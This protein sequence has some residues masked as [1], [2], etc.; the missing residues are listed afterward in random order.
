MSNKKEIQKYYPDNITK[1]I[2]RVA[3]F[4]SYNQEAK[5]ADYVIYYL[6][7]LKK[8]VDAIVFVTDN[9]TEEQ[10][11]KKIE[12]KIVYASCYNH[13]GYDFGSYKIG[14]RIAM[15]KGLLKEA[16]ELIF[17]ND[18]CY[19]PIFP[20]KNVFDTMASRSCDVWGLVESH[21]A[22]HHIQSFFMVFRRK[23]F[24]SSVFCNFVEE[25]HPLGCFMDYVN[26]YE[27]RFTVILKRA[28]F[29]TDVY[30][31]INKELNMQLAYWSGHGNTTT[32]P[33]TLYKLGM[34]LVKIKAMNGVF[35][36]LLNEST[37]QLLQMIRLDNKPLYDIIINDLAHKG[38]KPE[39]KWL[40]P[41]EIIGEAKIV[42]FDVFD[43]LLCRP[44]AHP[45]DLFGLIEEEK[46]AIGFKRER[47]AAEKAARIAHFNQPDVT[48]DQIYEKID[49]KFKDFMS[50]ELDYE[51]DLLFAKSDGKKIYD[52]AV[53]Q[54]KKVIAISDMYLSTEFITEVLHKNGFTDIVKVYVS[55]SIQACKGNGKLFQYVLNELAIKPSAMV[56]I[57]DNPIADKQAPEQLGIRS[58]LRMTNIDIIK[59]NNGLT[60]LHILAKKKCD[61]ALSMVQ[62]IIAQ[63]KVDNITESPLQGIGYELGG[64][65]AIGYVT[66]IHKIAKERN[67]DGIIFVSRDGYA[68]YK[69]YK[70]LYPDGIKGYYIQGSRKLILRN[71]YQYEDPQNTEY[72]YS[73]Y[74]E[75]CLDG[76]YLSPTDYAKHTDGI[77]NWTKK[78]AS[79]Y[80]EYLS[81]LHIDGNKLMTVDMTTRQYTSLKM[82]HEVLGNRIDCG[83]FSCSYGEKSA[84]TIL[85]YAKNHWQ[86]GDETYLMLAEELIT[87][88]ECSSYKINDDGTFVR[89]NWH[90]IEL[91]RI[92]N[93]KEILKGI[94]KFT[95]D[96]IRLTAKKHSVN[97]SY[98]DWLQ[99]AVNFIKYPNYGTEEL[100]KIIYHEDSL[101]S[102]FTNIH[103]MAYFSN[104]KETSTKIDDSDNYSELILL[105]N[106][107]QKYLKAIRK[108]SIA[109]GIETTTILF[110]LIYLIFLF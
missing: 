61:L 34:P 53:K 33:V 101:N 95:E 7:E 64:P 47:I 81:T 66:Y 6:T 17:L 67:I 93:Y 36:N 55:N 19:G 102:T 52:E 68:L 14:F 11:L 78:N 88:P 94:Y 63:H 75:E 1:N 65:L 109:L 30:V 79:L 20:F 8:E 40:T 91:Q 46:Q 25:L 62:S 45:T 107:R 13:K 9:E 80:Q 97:I 3:V 76:A 44:F 48:L 103:K 92:K 22:L 39:D 59:S 12:N 28:G 106:K 50:I 104:E 58:C 99:M 27:R 73:T 16:E 38:V 10:E 89:T 74:A 49:A 15:Q 43:T 71:N 24:T 23:V 26:L 77:S 5:I 85:T 2:K 56:H 41:T 84:F 57:G 70:K 29:T 69:V 96:Y 72:V 83:M 35:G 105:Q 60:R 31:P 21:E 42:S 82:M 90:P 87:A 86:A 32:F 37:Q 18:S 4:A 51:R 100:L 54:G 108:M 110:I 98:E